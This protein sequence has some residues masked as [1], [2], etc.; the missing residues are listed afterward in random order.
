MGFGRQCPPFSLCPTARPR[1]PARL[2][3]LGPVGLLL[4]AGLGC[5]EG[6]EG[7][8]WGPSRS[9]Q[10]S[11]A[12]PQGPPC[13]CGP[14][15]SLPGALVPWCVLRACSVPGTVPAEV[16]PFSLLD[17]GLRFRS[18]MRPGGPAPLPIHRWENGGSKRVANLP[19]AHVE[20][21][22]TEIWWWG[23]FLLL[24]VGQ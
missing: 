7:D 18:R 3:A 14:P 2:S 15:V 10:P 22:L 12:G 11:L 23:D 13:P 24:R 6:R 19:S 17:R 9:A 1:L 5:W 20:V 21:L 8:A 4:P 16:K